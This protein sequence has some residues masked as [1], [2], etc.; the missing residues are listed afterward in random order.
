[1]KG[2]V[3]CEHERNP[4]DCI[5][6]KQSPCKFVLDESCDDYCATHQQHKRECE[7]ATLRAENEAL[8]AEG[9]KDYDGMR[10][11]QAKFIKADHELRDLKAQNE[12]L[13]AALKEALA[14]IGHD[15]DCGVFVPFKPLDCNCA[16]K[17]RFNEAAY[18]HCDY[19]GSGSLA[20]CL[21]SLNGKVV[22]TY[23]CDDCCDHG[24][25]SDKCE[26]IKNPKGK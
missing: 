15:E 24:N 10:D 20:T 25:V 3:T 8:K 22:K 4:W 13:T 6:C 11:M 2:K 7:N 5:S 1:M 12:R 14:D 26:P 23:A 21:G 19:C 9:Q 17:K 18:P 16:L